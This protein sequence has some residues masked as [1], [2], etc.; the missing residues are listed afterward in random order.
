MSSFAITNFIDS[1]RS[2]SDGSLV[3]EDVTILRTVSEQQMPE[4]YRMPFP[5]PAGN[6]TIAPKEK[7]RH[8]RGLWHEL[9]Q[10]LHDLRYLTEAQFIFYHQHKKGILTD[11]LLQDPVVEA[12]RSYL[13]EEKEWPALLEILRPG[14]AIDRFFLSNHLAVIVD[15][16]GLHTCWDG[17]GVVPN[18]Y[19]I[20][21]RTVF[22]RALSYRLQ[23]VSS[24]QFD[25][26]ELPNYYGGEKLEELNR[27][28]TEGFKVR[29]NASER[30]IPRGFW[31]KL[32]DINALLVSY[33]NNTEKRKK[34]PPLRY[35]LPPQDGDD[36]VLLEQLTTKDLKADK[37]TK[38]SN[39]Y[40]H[41]PTVRRIRRGA[42]RRN[43]RPDNGLDIRLLQV[44]LWQAGYYTGAID[45]NWGPLS[46]IALKHFLMDEA[47]LTAE[48]ISPAPSDPVAFQK[49]LKRKQPETAR[50]VRSLL[51]KIN[52]ANEVY[53]ADFIGIIRVFTDRIATRE[54]EMF[55]SERLSDEE[56]LLRKLPTNAGISHDQFDNQILNE[57]GVGELFPDNTQH[58]NRRVSFFR[59]VGGFIVGGLGKIVD[60]LKKGV[61]AIGRALGK[62]LGPVF[63]F[64]KKMMR[65]IRSAIKRFFSGFKYLASFVFGKPLL[66]EVAP[67][68]ATESARVFG[69]RF[70][71]DFDAVNFIP[72]DFQPG[73]PAL[74]ANH[75]NRMRHDMTYFIDGVVWIIKAIGKLSN[76]GGWVWLGWQ[77]VRALGKRV[78][79]VV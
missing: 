73:E 64:I 67:A 33:I 41:L 35:Q 29:G 62:L 27:L 25:L 23:T 37:A 59:R 51:V 20:G 15:R 77:I 50:K 36:F 46:H 11:P 18:K 74:H 42:K 75:I 21:E 10:H 26:G 45:E 24:S 17:A 55:R 22:G 39:K 63:T 38:I 57:T 13:L 7:S 31:T 30:K 53:A 12:V 79:A 5:D 14:N 69:T 9:V 70:Q 78:F 54:R 47:D 71:L 58:S 52:D 48:A 66:T 44:K 34:N 43:H 32:L 60:W 19:F 65:P 76:P 2:F 16:I 56:D 28:F 4:R 8:L 1:C 6:P 49:F 72:N 61:Q 40:Y 3:G 68:T